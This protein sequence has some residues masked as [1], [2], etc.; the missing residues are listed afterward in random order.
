M[1]ELT[2]RGLMKVAVKRVLATGFSL[3]G[4]AWLCRRLAKPAV[5]MLVYHRIVKDDEVGV[6]PYISVTADN[7]KRQIRHFKRCYRIISLEEAV[8]RLKEGRIDR[9]YLVVTFDDGYA[10]NYL[11]GLPIFQEEQVSPAIFVTTGCVE[12]GEPLWPD[13]LRRMVYGYKGKFPIDL[14]QFGVTL[15]E[16][17]REKIS[18]LK[19]LIAHGKKLD[20][21]ARARF[22]EQVAAV[23][24]QPGESSSLMLDWTQVERLCSEGITIGSHTINHP[25]LSN[26]SDAVIV[27]EISESKK[28]LEAKTGRPVKFFA[29]PN[30]TA[31]DFTNNTMAHL[32]SAG[33]EAAVT[34]MRGANRPGCDLFRL[35]RTGVYVTD[36]IREIEMKLSIESLLS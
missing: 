5:F 33:Y 23:F 27:D 22:L 28:M 13:L 36:G 1:I 29:Y 21:F 35:R 24:G 30:G 2:L 9:N 11:P 3:G 26:V 31:C 6:L 16:G 17:L 19:T 12:R 14:P 34:T 7:L 18:V 32:K 20:G 25:V 8:G 4:G 15:R 10:D